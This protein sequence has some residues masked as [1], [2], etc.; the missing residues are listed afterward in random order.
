MSAFRWRDGISYP[1]GAQQAGEHLE[2]LEAHHGHLS[3]QIVLDDSKPEEALLHPCFEWDDAKAADKWRK[4]EARV[5]IGGLVTVQVAQA[6]NE[7]AR[8]V[9][10]RAFSRTTTDNTAAV[11]N[12]TMLAMSEQKAR[13]TILDNARREMEAYVKKYKDLVDISGILMEFAGKEDHGNS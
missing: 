13:D 5:L 2:K 10:I 9:T 4:Q 11:Y 7:D 12:S 3:A 8:K 6:P 1:V